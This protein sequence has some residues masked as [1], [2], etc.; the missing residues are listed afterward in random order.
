MAGSAVAYARIEADGT[1]DVA[2]SKNI[3]SARRPTSGS[4]PVAGVYC[5]KPSVPVASV[6]TSVPHA[7]ADEGVFAEASLVT[8]GDEASN[9]CPG[10]DWISTWH[11]T[12]PVN[13][14]V[15]VLFN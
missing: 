7:F 12:T 8:N 14:A 2:H 3:E 4:S 9:F 11:G 15:Y 13:H 1:L 5:I 10:E 6:V